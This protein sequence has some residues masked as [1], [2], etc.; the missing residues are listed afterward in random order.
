MLAPA[1]DRTAGADARGVLEK[2]EDEAARHRAG[3]LQAHGYV[4][5]Q[6]E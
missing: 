4:L 6:P 2:V 5:R 3:F 1:A